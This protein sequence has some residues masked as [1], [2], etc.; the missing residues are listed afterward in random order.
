MTPKSNWT[1]PWLLL[2]D[3]QS[4][5]I[6]TFR[7]GNENHVTWRQGMQGCCG[8]AERFCLCLIEQYSEGTCQ[9]SKQ[10]F[11]C[12]IGAWRAAVIWATVEELRLQCDPRQAV[13][14]TGKPTR[15]LK[16]EHVRRDDDA[17]KEV[18][19]AWGR[20]LPDLLHSLHFYFSL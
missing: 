2:L 6:R 14:S 13:E 9:R 17:L 1:P 8:G 4:S 19:V 10:I 11:R 16:R 18:G 5:W 15:S 3:L 7:F 20:L 12:A